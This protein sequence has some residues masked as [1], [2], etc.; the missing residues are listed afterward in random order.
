MTINF[1]F[2]LKLALRAI[3]ALEQL[4][5]DY[6]TV[7]QQELELAETMNKPVDKS[8]GRTYYQDD[9]EI[10]K[11]EQKA[12]AQRLLEYGEEDKS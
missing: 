12:K 9:R 2:S 5:R 3:R 10:W 11:A 6:R 7:H 4:A 8:V 1:N